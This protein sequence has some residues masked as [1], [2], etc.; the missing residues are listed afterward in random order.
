LN[1]DDVGIDRKL[2]ARS[3]KIGGIGEQAFEAMVES[4]RQRRSTGD[5]VALDVVSIDKKERRADCEPDLGQG[6]PLYRISAM[7]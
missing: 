7:A 6:R 3:E 4:V 2:S 5:R 1:L